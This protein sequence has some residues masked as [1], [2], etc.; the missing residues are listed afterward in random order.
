[1]ERK[2]THALWIV[3]GI[4]AQGAEKTWDVTEARPLGGR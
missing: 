1:M 2:M 3:A 4:L